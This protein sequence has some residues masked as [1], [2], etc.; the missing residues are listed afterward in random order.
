[1]PNG[2]ALRMR[3]R[4]IEKGGKA[5]I[6][7]EGSR[8]RLM[9]FLEESRFTL[10]HAVEVQAITENSVVAK[11]KRNASQEGKDNVTVEAD[12]VILA[13]GYSSD[14]KLLKSL[15]VW[16]AGYTPEGQTNASGVFSCALTRSLKGGNMRNARSQGHSLH[17]DIEDS[18][19]LVADV[20]KSV[21]QRLGAVW[22]EE[23]VKSR[24]DECPWRVPLKVLS[25][26]AEMYRNKVV[27]DLG[28]RKSDGAICWA[29]YAQ[30]VT[31]TK[32]KKLGASIHA[33]F[34]TASLHP[35]Q[36]PGLL[37]SL[38]KLQDSGQVSQFAQVVLKWDVT[39]N[40][41]NWES[42]KPFAH[43]IKD[44]HFEEVEFEVVLDR[45]SPNA[46]PIGLNLDSMQSSVTISY[47]HSGL[48]SAWNQA[49]PDKAVQK[50]D[51]IVAINGESG[52]SKRLLQLLS[53]RQILRLTIRRPTLSGDGLHCSQGV[54]KEHCVDCK[55]HSHFV[56][57]VFQLRNLSVSGLQAL[58]QA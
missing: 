35:D 1:M 50:Q 20:A 22:C 58:L 14:I 10:Y 41:S 27:V 56:L 8:Q 52:S 38:R 12:R 49:H 57:G 39:T 54:I 18:S 34:Y 47:L 13:L 30:S 5:N 24:I 9:H 37:L 53:L 40:S 2:T 28:S 29:K 51:H 26:E 19:G 4:K 42:L 3:I 48:A 23:V 21:L 44:F 55:H 36:Y 31:T 45:S 32:P 6:Y 17:T 7:M 16:K 11:V 33:D 46:I 43:Q 15:N 25:Y